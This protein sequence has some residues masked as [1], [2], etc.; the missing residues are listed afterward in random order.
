MT[1]L[2]VSEGSPEFLPAATRLIDSPKGYIP[3]LDGMRA[4]CVSLVMVAHAGFEAV[5]PGGLGVTVF[6]FLSG[7]L[8]TGLLIDEKQASGRVSLKNFYLRRFLRLSPELGLL[9]LYGITIGLLYR[10]VSG[11]DILSALTYT[12]NY[13]NLYRESIGD[14]TIR[15]PHLWSLAVEEHFYLTFPLLMVFVADRPRLLCGAMVGVCCVALAWRIAIVTGGTPFDLP[16]TY[17]Y[18]ASDARADS[19]AYGCLTAVLFKL[20]PSRI[21]GAGLG[22]ALLGAALVLLAA[23]LAI[24]GFYFRETWRYSLQGMALLLLFVAIF[25]NSHCV[26]II[27]LL[28]NPILKWLGS[29]SYGAYL[30]HMEGVTLYHRFVGGEGDHASM[31][32]RIGAVVT[33]FVF[34]FVVAHFSF[35]AT[36]PVRGL[37][38]KFHKKALA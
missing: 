26:W 1:T 3:G 36:A 4:I 38:R 15:W 10:P 2:Q 27:T 37:R 35:A 9:L 29:L 21:E 34:A 23:S 12:S 16:A 19:I 14:G 7:F 11:V 24:R 5:V 20:F 22:Y 6:F 31:A 17:T 33:C 30:W 25:R 18:I 32:L 13:V 8:I 28:E